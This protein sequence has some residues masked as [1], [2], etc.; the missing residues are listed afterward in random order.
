MILIILRS[1]I[2]RNSP[3]ES[4]KRS[5]ETITAILTENIASDDIQIDEKKVIDIIKGKVA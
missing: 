4:R 1:S 3:L 2:L 5:K